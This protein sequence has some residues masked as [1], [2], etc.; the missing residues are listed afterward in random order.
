MG[1]TRERITGADAHLAAGLRAER[2]R[3]R[4]TQAEIATRTGLAR[5]TISAIEDQRRR[6][7]LSDC[8]RICVA[9]GVPLA[10]LLAGADAEESRRALGL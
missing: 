2:A 3:Q 7:T 9:L 8:E 10:A 4:L 5:S 6:V 1:G